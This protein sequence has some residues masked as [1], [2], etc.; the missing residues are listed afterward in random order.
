[1]AKREI[2]R[3]LGISRV[4]VRKVRRSNSAAVPEV[5]RSQ[6]VE[7]YRQ[8]IRELFDQ[9]K[10]NLVR[11]QEELRAGGGELSYAALTAFCRRHGIG[12]QPPTPA[13]QYDF[14][15]GEELPQD[16]SPHELQ[17]AGKKRKVQTVERLPLRPLPAWIP[18]VYRRPQ[19]LVD[20]EGYLARHTN[21]YAVPVDWIGRRGASGRRGPI[22]IRNRRPFSPPRPS[23]PTRWRACSSAAARWS[24]WPCGNCCGWCGSTHANRCWA[25]SPRPP[26]TGFTTWTGWSA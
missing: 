9:S 13:G 3:V 7:P 1:V 18:E 10:G 6:K 26:V 19:R 16:P 24:R 17:L 12:Y 21:R 2:A 23:W 22:R 11:V 5:N 20:S 8:Q 14:A 4:A 15:P 25:R